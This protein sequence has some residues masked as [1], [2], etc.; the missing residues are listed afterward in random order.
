MSGKTRSL[1]TLEDLLALSGPQ[2]NALVILAHAITVL[3]IAG[4]DEEE[5]EAYVREATSSDYN[6]L[7]TV[8]E[9][10]LDEV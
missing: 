6:N 1:R 5:I 9:R 4:C 3:H 8:T 2:G 10:Y 7:N